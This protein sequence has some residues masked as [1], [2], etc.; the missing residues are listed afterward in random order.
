M[1]WW[2]VGVALI[3]TFVVG[4]EARAQQADS[5]RAGVRPKADSARAA[6]PGG[7]QQPAPA[8]RRGT[9][10]RDSLSAPVSPGRAF[11]LS[12][13]VPGLGQSRLN[14]PT[15]GA[16]YFAS[17][18]VWLAMLAKSA[19]DLRIAKAHARDVIVATYETDPVTGAPVIRNGQ[20]VAKDTLR[21]KYADPVETAGGV[22]GQ[23]QQRS[24]VKARRLHFEDWIAMLAF[25]HLFAAADAFVSS[26]LW[27]LPAQVEMRA[28][29]RGTGIGLSIPFR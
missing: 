8:R 9:A 28:L 3:A 23:Q 22:G 29:P 20:Y 1:P 26:Q 2:G 24:R 7:A 5:A 21:S 18:A 11:F 16:V 17:E 25:N 19:N 15:A 4:H 27:D 13:A 10:A 6:A 12:L 14:R